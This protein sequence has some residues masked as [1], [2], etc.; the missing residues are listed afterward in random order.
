MQQNN[1]T[2]MLKIPFPH[3]V[4]K[5]YSNMNKY[6]LILFLWFSFDFFWTLAIALSATRQYLF[7]IVFKDFLRITWLWFPSLLQHYFKKNKNIPNHF[8]KMFRGMSKHHKS[9]KWKCAPCSSL[10]FLNIRKVW[11]QMLF[12]SLKL[13]NLILTLWTLGVFNIWRFESLK[14]GSWFGNL[15][16]PK[17]QFWKFWEVETSTFWIFGIQELI[18]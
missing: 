12:R 3:M 11:S 4:N 15:T 1:A 17:L 16:F 14:N 5:N 9:N 18:K 7:I 10:V 6:A 2:A 13:Q 8:R